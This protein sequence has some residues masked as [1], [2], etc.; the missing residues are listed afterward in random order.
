MPDRVGNGCGR[1]PACPIV[2]SLA[3]AHGGQF[4]VPIGRRWPEIQV[5]LPR[6]VRVNGERA[7]RT[8]QFAKIMNGGVT[9]S[10]NRK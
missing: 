1:A 5:G 9:G 7:R 8:R 4:T 2:Q 6:R 3:A 10:L